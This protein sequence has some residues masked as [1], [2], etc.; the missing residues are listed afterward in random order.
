LEGIRA[1]S[2][3]GTRVIQGFEG[4]GLLKGISN[5]RLTVYSL[6]PQKAIGNESCLVI[7]QLQAV[8]NSRNTINS[9]NKATYKIARRFYAFSASH[10]SNALR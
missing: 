1:G 10:A 7:G 4:K 8:S 9:T 6:N 5:E 3:G 2:E